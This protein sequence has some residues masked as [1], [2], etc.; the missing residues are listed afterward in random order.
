MK[1]GMYVKVGMKTGINVKAGMKTEQEQ[2]SLFVFRPLAS[3]TKNMN[4]L[5]IYAAQQIFQHSSIDNILFY[6]LISN[7]RTLHVLCICT[8]YTNIRPDF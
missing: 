5:H 1:T 3:F 4:T 6:L 8:M 7:T 2:E